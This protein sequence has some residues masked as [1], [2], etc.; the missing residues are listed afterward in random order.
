[1]HLEIRAQ[2]GFLDK[3]TWWYK[4]LLLPITIL[5][6]SGGK[7]I[8]YGLPFVQIHTLKIWKE[9]ILLNHLPGKHVFFGHVTGCYRMLQ[10]IG[11]LRQWNCHPPRIHL[12]SSR[13]VQGQDGIRPMEFHTTHHIE[14]WISCYLLTMITHRIHVYMYGIFA[15]IYHKKSTKCKYTIHGSN[16]IHGWYTVDTS[17]RNSGDHQ[18]TTWWVL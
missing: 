3:E 18:F 10:K 13:P 14:G 9:L 8:S 17:N 11:H 6:S 16:G 1:M 5:I 7:A 4:D 12:P 15:Y 2:Y